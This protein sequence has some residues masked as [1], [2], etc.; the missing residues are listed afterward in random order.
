MALC[1]LARVGITIDRGD[2][3]CFVERG[4]SFT[5]KR[6]FYFRL[7]EVAF[8]LRRKGGK[9]PD[10][11][12]GIWERAAEII[13]NG[14]HLASRGGKRKGEWVEYREG[15]RKIGAKKKMTTDFEK[16]KWGGSKKV[17]QIKGETEFAFA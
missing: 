5:G 4:K 2:I 17:V 15:G 10:S 6:T 12:A 11:A 3:T 14:P 16:G 13:L 1:S 8:L 7:P 9:R